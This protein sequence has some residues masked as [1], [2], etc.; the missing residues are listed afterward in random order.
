MPHLPVVRNQK[1]AQA[2]DPDKPALVEVPGK[3]VSAVVALIEAMQNPGDNEVGETIKALRTLEHI[4]ALV[5]NIGPYSQAAKAGLARGDVL[6]RYDERQIGKPETLISLT[7][8]TEASKRVAVQAR[9]G[10]Q[11]LR[12][13]VFGGRL[14]ITIS[15]LT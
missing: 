8:R 3:R 5:T 2:H 1:D 11:E 4:G 6:L 9:R 10:A 15:P 12:F 7:K 13:E 14:G